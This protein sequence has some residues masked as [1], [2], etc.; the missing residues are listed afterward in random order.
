[1]P[2]WQKTNPLGEHEII[3]LI[4]KQLTTMPDMPVPFGDDVSA[5]PLLGGGMAVLKT[6]MLVAATDV[7]P[8]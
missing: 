4:K 3:Q 8:E 7:P 6:D 1:M 5:A 2:A